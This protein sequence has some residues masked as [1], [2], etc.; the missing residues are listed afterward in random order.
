MEGRLG[1]DD[2]NADLAFDSIPDPEPLNSSTATVSAATIAST[3]F[4]CNTPPYAFG[5][6][7]PAV[8]FSSS[9]FGFSSYCSTSSAFGVGA[10]NAFGST[11]PAFGFSNAAAAVVSA[12]PAFGF[13]N[14][15]AAVVSTA[16]AF[17]ASAASTA[18]TFVHECHSSIAPFKTPV[19]L[20]FAD[21]LI[22]KHISLYLDTGGLVLPP[23][24]QRL[25]IMRQ[26]DLIK[27]SSWFF[28]QRLPSIKRHR[29]DQ[30]L[31]L[32]H[33]STQFSP[34]LPVRMMFGLVATA[35]HLL[36]IAPG[37]KRLTDRATSRCTGSIME[38]VT[39]VRVNGVKVLTSCSPA[40][41]AFNAR[42]S[43]L[44]PISRF[45]SPN[46]TFQLFILCY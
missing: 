41:F 8:S 10:A 29:K 35:C 25:Q 16:P 19:A 4:G 44:L 42:C 11:A 2:A 21:S 20:R 37:D 15:A 18:P 45:V 23:A 5:I 7:A 1:Q 24:G 3:A 34:L 43:K 12:A 40:F 9:V 28:A 13:S 30:S 46:H 31:P 36:S 32:G 38:R 27:A 39:R 33:L 22:G 6:D 26:F 17:G 14:A